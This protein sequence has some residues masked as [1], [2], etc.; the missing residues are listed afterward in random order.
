MA[1]HAPSPYE[2]LVFIMK[3]RY[4]AQGPGNAASKTLYDQA[5]VA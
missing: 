1:H 4:T 5:C 2:S 3:N